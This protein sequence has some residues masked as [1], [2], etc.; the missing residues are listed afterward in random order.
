MSMRQIYFYVVFSDI[1][2]DPGEDVPL[3]IREDHVFVDDE[4]TVVSC[5]RSAGF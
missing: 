4:E 2:V 1:W 3:R 5:K